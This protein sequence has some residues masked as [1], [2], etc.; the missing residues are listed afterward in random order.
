MIMKDNQYKKIRN[1]KL[2][3]FDNS[4][5]LAFREQLY[6]NNFKLRSKLIVRLIF[7]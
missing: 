3:S 1:I 6:L 7:R 2:I 5:Y 4:E